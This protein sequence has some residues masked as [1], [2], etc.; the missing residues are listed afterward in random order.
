MRIGSRIIEVA[1]LDKVMFPDMGITQGDL[2][3]Y[4]RR[5]ADTMLPYLEER[6]LTMQR[7]PDGIGRCRIVESPCGADF[8]G[9]DRYLSHCPSTT[10][11]RRPASPD[12]CA[13]PRRSFFQALLGEAH[14]TWAL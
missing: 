1:N 6:P 11:L 7:F 14:Y 9:S 8:P 5:I 13:P 2:V 10:S 3:D 12:A 4:Y